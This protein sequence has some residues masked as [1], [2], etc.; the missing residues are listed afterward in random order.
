LPGPTQYTIL[1]RV[2]IFQVP[3]CL[4]LMTESDS[5][6]KTMRQGLDAEALMRFLAA[7]SKS[8]VEAGRLFGVLQNKLIGYFK[9]KG[10]SEPES[11]AGETIDRAA[12]KLAVGVPIPDMQR[13]C[14]GIARNIAKEQLR[15]QVTELTANKGAMDNIHTDGS[16]EIDRINNVLAPCLKLLTSEDLILLSK[17][18]ADLRGKARA[19]HRRALAAAEHTSAAALRVRITRLRNILQNCANAKTRSQRD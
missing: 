6:S 16:E 8:E 10:V 15:K 18:C 14:F 2:V 19:D 13:F 5:S 12:L 9:M 4:H 17:Y 1:R 11:A 7:L 3:D